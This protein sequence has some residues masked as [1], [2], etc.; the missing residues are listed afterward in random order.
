MQEDKPVK[1]QVETYLLRQDAGTE[2][3]ERDLE[4]S[5]IIIVVNLDSDQGIWADTERRGSRSS[6]DGGGDDEL[7]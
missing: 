3:S 6:H 2:V 1:A 5:S 7:R 4:A